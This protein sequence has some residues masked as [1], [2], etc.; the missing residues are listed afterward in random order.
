MSGAKYLDS[1]TATIF[2]LPI[3]PLT[4]PVIRE[5]A[6]DG[7]VLLFD[8][9]DST[10][11]T[12][13]LSVWNPRTG[14]RLVNS[15]AAVTSAFSATGTRIATE[16]NAV[17]STQS[18]TRALKLRDLND[19]TGGGYTL[20]L[21]PLHSY[22]RYAPSVAQPAWDAAGSQLIYRNFSYLTSNY[23]LQVW[24]PGDGNLSHTILNHPEGIANFAFS[25]DGNIIWAVTG[26]NRLI[27][28]TIAT[29]QLDEIL[30]PL[31]ATGVVFPY[32]VP[33]SAFF[34][35]GKGFSAN[36]SGFRQRCAPSRN[37]GAAGRLIR[38][39]PVGFR[40]RYPPICCSIRRGQSF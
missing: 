26:S 8:R 31:P 39:S 37:R 28:L 9:P 4:R 10:S 20:V 12:G 25:G 32:G 2:D 34:I 3:S 38:S 11:L 40:A 19:L 7:T 33:G 35:T 22:D 27:R 16:E 13:T 21:D 5:I 23:A 29:G 6:N 24:K 30:P 14:Q 15:S 1:Q 18:G 17:Q 36:V